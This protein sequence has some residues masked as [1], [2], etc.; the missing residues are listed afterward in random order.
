MFELF[1]YLLAIVFVF[2][3]TSDPE[4]ELYPTGIAD[5][6][7]NSDEEV[8]RTASEVESLNNVPSSIAPN[9][10]SREIF[11]SSPY[12]YPWIAAKKTAEEN[13]CRL[14]YNQLRATHSYAY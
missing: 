9:P 7:L 10:Y 13:F 5:G 11:P 1:L 8:G 12:L 14:D 6:K 4:K 2:W 3:L